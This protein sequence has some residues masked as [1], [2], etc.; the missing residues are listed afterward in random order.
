MGG[1]SRIIEELYYAMALDVMY[2]VSPTATQ[3]YAKMAFGQKSKSVEELNMETAYPKVTNSVTTIIESTVSSERPNSGSDK[4]SIGSLLD[5]SLIERSELA[6][7][8]LVASR[9]QLEDEIEVGNIISSY[10][11]VALNLCCCTV[12]ST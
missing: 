6:V 7:D 2:H 3:A 11:S 4:S 9:K 5:F 8:Q 1:V 10:L 12:Y